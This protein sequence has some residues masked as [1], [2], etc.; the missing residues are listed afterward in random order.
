MAQPQ[1]SAAQTPVTGEQVMAAARAQEEKKARSVWLHAWHDPVAN[2]KAFTPCV[3]FADLSGD[4][5]SKCMVA[6][7]DKKLKIYTGPD[8]PHTAQQPETLQRTGKKVS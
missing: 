6:S 1:P 2:L 5:E 3:R 4:G 7:S 8:H